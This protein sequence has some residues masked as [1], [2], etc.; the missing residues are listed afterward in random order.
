MVLNGS[1]A[2]FVSERE[3][4]AFRLTLDMKAAFEKEKGKNSMKQCAAAWFNCF[5]SNRGNGFEDCIRELKEYGDLYLVLDEIDS[6]QTRRTDA[7]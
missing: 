4:E 1:S 6:M 7:Q 2:G 3:K 5:N